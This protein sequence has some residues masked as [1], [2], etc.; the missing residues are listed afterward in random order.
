MSKIFILSKHEV[1]STL[2]RY[3]DTKDFPKR[4]G[5]DLDWEWGELPDLD[6]ETRA[7]LEKDGNKGWV[8]GPCLWLDGQRVVVGSEKGKL[9]REDAEIEKK[10]PIVYAADYT[11]FPVHAH[12]KLNSVSKSSSSAAKIPIVNGTALPHHDA[13]EAAAVAAGGQ[14][15][16]AV[17][18]SRTDGASEPQ[19]QPA[20]PSTTEPTTTS[21]AQPPSEH[22]HPLPG[23][24]SAHSQAM[25]SAISSQLSEESVSSIP[26]TA[27][28][29]ASATI[30]ANGHV[31]ELAPGEIL[32]ASDTSKGLAIETEKLS[33][34]TGQAK[35]NVVERPPMERFVTAAEV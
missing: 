30:T 5:G 27:N 26:A 16:A 7:A 13:E 15:I 23:A 2:S 22:S 29:H 1:K 19:S 28:G 33:L 18:A 20:Q 21:Q 6:G 32:V 25:T 35:E 24:L 11:E 8:R 9:R 3:M 31:S 17:I 12:L 34:G 10:K 14:T 4:Y